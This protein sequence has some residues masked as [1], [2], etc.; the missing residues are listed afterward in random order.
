LNVS[1]R[2]L[3]FAVLLSLQT[4]MMPTSKERKNQSSDAERLANRSIVKKMAMRVIPQCDNGT[5]LSQIC[6]HLFLHKKKFW[7]AAIA[8]GDRIPSPK[9]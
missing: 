4:M 8:S 9:K 1:Y 7:N 6:N 2:R 5:R 3:V